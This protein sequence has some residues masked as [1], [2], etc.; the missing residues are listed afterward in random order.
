MCMSP[1]PQPNGTDRHSVVRGWRAG[2]SQCSVGAV[3]G[4]AE[5]VPNGITVT[6]GG[7]SQVIGKWNRRHLEELDRVGHD[8]L[9]RRSIVRSSLLCTLH[10]ESD[11]PMRRQRGEG[12]VR[13]RAIAALVSIPSSAPACPGPIFA[14]V[15]EG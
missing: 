9:T 14:F 1:V 11:E 2:H 12:Y 3:L 6:C 8:I 5:P 13:F 7:V 10:Y 4:E 15:Q